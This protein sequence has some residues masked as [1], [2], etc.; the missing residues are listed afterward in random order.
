M[1][2]CKGP[3]F[4]KVP[5]LVE[6]LQSPKKNWA[7]KEK[8]FPYNLSNLFERTEIAKNAASASRGMIRARTPA[9]NSG[10]GM[11]GAV[12]SSKITLFPPSVTV[13][14]RV[15]PLITVEAVYELP[16]LSAPAAKR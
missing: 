8:S 16:S 15:T 10:V 1:G 6:I 9:G 14:D 13:P 12:G 4:G 5:N 3:P 7:G 11:D 2:E